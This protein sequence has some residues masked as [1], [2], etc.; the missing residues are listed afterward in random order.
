MRNYLLYFFLLISIAACKKSSVANTT[1]NIDISTGTW[2][3]SYFLDEQIKTNNY[4]G[5]FFMFLSG[6]T[7]MAH[8]STTIIT[9]T[10]SQTGTRI[11]INFTNPAMTDLNGDWLKTEFTNS[12]IKLKN[13]NP[14][15]ND[16]LYFEK[17]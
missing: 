9:G 13:D 3:I 14:S 5:Y 4:S 11:N 17:N 16:L 10:W 8:G 12:S 6:G 7:F 1:P 15:Q 2:R